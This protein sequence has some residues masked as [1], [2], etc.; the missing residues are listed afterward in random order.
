MRIRLGVFVPH[1]IS[2][3]LLHIPH[4]DQLLSGHDI[5]IRQVVELFD[6]LNRHIVFFTNLV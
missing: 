5:F 6:L 1:L 2:D 3:K 4:K